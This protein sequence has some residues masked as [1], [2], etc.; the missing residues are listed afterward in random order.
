MN[1]HTVTGKEGGV[2][3]TSS[4]GNL[5]SFFDLDVISRLKSQPKTFQDLSKIARL[6][7]VSSVQG[8]I[9]TAAKLRSPETKLQT[10]MKRFNTDNKSAQNSVADQ[11]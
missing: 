11:A 6:L 4:R 8:N 7:E 5:E 10:A 2:I 9:Y 1:G 3:N